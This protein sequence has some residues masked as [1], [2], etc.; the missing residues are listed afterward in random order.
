MKHKLISSFFILFLIVGI[1][2]A[3]KLKNTTDGKVKWSLEI[4]GVTVAE[5]KEFN[6]SDYIGQRI[7]MLKLQQMMI[8]WVLISK[9]L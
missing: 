6:S 9:G 5:V 1:A 3:M 4:N 2:Y 8:I 7:Q